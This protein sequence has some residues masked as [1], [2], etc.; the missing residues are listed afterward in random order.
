[1][2]ERRAHERSFVRAAA[3]N[4][5]AFS[6]L[7]KQPN[8][9]RKSAR[10]TEVETETSEFP[11]H[12]TSRFREGGGPTAEIGSVRLF[13]FTYGRSATNENA[14]ATDFEAEVE[15]WKAGRATFL[16]VS[17]LHCA[18]DRGVRE[19]TELPLFAD[20]GGFNYLSSRDGNIEK[21]ETRDETRGVSRLFGIENSLAETRMLVPLSDSHL[22]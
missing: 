6:P 3:L 9:F 15:C 2:K 10:G 4:G 22:A 19:E 14:P 7:A 17:S 20:N 18:D 11:P 21:R 1:M 5:F 8:S 12:N 13:P 16:G